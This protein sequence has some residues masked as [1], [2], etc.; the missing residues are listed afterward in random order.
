MLSIL[1]KGSKGRG[2]VHR[3]IIRC[4][5]AAVNQKLKEIPKVPEFLHSAT[6]QERDIYQLMDCSD[7]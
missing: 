7:L 1:Q 5:L 4:I 6:I 3:H 2:P